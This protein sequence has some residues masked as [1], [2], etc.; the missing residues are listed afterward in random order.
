ME[1]CTCHYK[2]DLNWLK[3][4]EFPVTVVQKEGGVQH[5]FTNVINLPNIGIEVSAYLAF[6]ITRYNDLPEYTAFI[7]GHETTYHQQGERNFL[8]M[9]RTANIKKYD[10]IPLNN[11]WRTMISESCLNEK[12]K[13]LSEKIGVFFPELIIFEMGSQFITSKKAI[14]SRPRL[15]Y[16]YLMNFTMNEPSSIDMGLLFEPLW[17]CIFT[18]R[19]SIFPKEDYFSP[20]LKEILFF[21]GCIPVK[22]TQL[23]F[24]LI[25]KNPY[26]GC[27]HIKD[28]TIFDYYKIRGT[29]FIV[30][31]NYKTDIDY[32]NIS[33]TSYDDERAIPFIMN[34]VT[35]LYNEYNNLEN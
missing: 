32:E 9:I 20:P 7:H 1:I 17:H 12:T 28:Q 31:N 21:Y 19:N 27:I 11:M 34:A 29:I 4:S 30:D 16:E 18:H 24:G 13:E 5:P 2:E 35:Q 22:P 10:F 26:E 25:S 14:L 33:F 15:F 23:K 3:Q 6:I 8:D